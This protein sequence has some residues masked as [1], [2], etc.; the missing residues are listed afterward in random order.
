M[1]SNNIQETYDQYKLIVELHYGELQKLVEA[2]G[3]PLEGNCF[4]YHGTTREFPELIAK[5]ANL[6]WYTLQAK[7]IAE[8]GFNAGHS[9]AAMMALSHEDTEF[10]FFDIGEHAYT[11]PCFAYLAQTLNRASSVV[12][13]DSR[14]AIPDYIQ[15]HPD[16]INSYDVVHVDGG[17]A[18]SCFFSDMACALILAKKGGIIIIDDTQLDYIG[19]WANTLLQKKIVELVPQLPTVGYKHIVVRKI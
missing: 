12:I 11:R 19:D 15:K 4:S 18:E 2:S 13:G 16:C 10:T 5:R 9:A 1:A 3:E 6:M 14:I 7:K 8:I 17:H